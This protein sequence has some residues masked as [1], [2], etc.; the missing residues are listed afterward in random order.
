MKHLFLY[1]L[2][3]YLSSLYGTIPPADPQQYL[4]WK[5]IE[6]GFRHADDPCG[7]PA[8]Y[9][10]SYIV[11]NPCYVT[12]IK[13]AESVELL[14]PDQKK[15]TVYLAGISCARNSIKD[16]QKAKIFLKE[17]LLNQR[18]LLLLHE[19]D[20]LQARRPRIVLE[21]GDEDVNYEMLITGLADYRDEDY[22]LGGYD[23]CRYELAAKEAKA[24][25]L[26]IWATK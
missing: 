19:S 6:S 5:L 15:Q 4:S 21:I 10:D 17:R 3:H 25:K 16:N 11:V 9:S 7:D 23:D 2:L 20:D 26:G 24:N 14:L 13:S 1:C 22:I 8:R 18:I 12:K